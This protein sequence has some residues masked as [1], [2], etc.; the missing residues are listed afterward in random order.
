MSCGGTVW[1]SPRGIYVLPQD[2]VHVWRASLDRMEGHLASLMRLLSPDERERADRFHFET[3]RKRCVVARG[4]LRLLL[5]HC[6]GRCAN[7]VQFRY[8]EFGKP[9]LADGLHPSLQFNLSHSGDLVLIALSRGRALGVDIEQ[10][11][12]DVAAKEIA[13][14]FFSADECWR[15]ATVAQAVQCA[16]FFACWTRKEAYLK[17]RG[18]GLSLS[19]AQFDVSFLPG[20][21]PRLL[22]TR[23][24]PADV[25]RWTLHALEGGEGYQAALA[26]EGSDWKLKCLAWQ[27]ATVGVRVGDCSDVP[28]LHAFRTSSTGLFGS[29]KS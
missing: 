20:D 16:A 4:L 5:G 9:I 3:D 19:L 21:Q 7:Q 24:D 26:V 8:N 22:A 27:A 17:A 10:M 18:D 1:H 6:L 13:A 14:R 12:V 15:L 23:H 2:E 28:A 29:V 11:R 25:H